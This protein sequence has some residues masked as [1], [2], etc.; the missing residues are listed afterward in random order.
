MSAITVRSALHFMDSPGP[1]L[2]TTLEFNAECH[3]MFLVQEPR[4]QHHTISV[5]I[6]KEGL[7]LCIF[8]VSAEIHSSPKLPMKPEKSQQ[9]IQT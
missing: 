2:Y 6:P 3:G 7:D 4:N 8:S 1:F 5:T 9:H